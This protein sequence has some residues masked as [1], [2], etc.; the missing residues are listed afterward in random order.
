MVEKAIEPSVGS[1]GLDGFAV[2]ALAS[3][4]SYHGQTQIITDC[5]MSQIKQQYAPVP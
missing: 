3:S 1:E 2:V 4:A 5:M